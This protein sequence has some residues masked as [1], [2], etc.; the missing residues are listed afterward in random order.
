MN[1]YRPTRGYCAFDFEI[2]VIPVSQLVK[3][4]IY[5]GIE[6]LEEGGALTASR[7][8]CDRYGMNVVFMF[9]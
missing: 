6:H 9:S 3:P 4:W 2:V 7:Q 1:L 5:R 8:A